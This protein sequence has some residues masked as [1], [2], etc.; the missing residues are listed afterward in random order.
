V[1]DHG[2][3]AHEEG[4]P[5][6]AGTRVE[7][8]NAFDGTWTTGFVIVELTGGG[9]RIERRSDGEQ[10]PVTMPTESVRRERRRSM[11]WY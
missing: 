1:S 7:V 10:L 2:D 6:P 4:D 8:R 9:Y 5:L 3:R 11:W